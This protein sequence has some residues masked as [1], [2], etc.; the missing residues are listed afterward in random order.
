MFHIFLLANKVVLIK[1]TAL[2]YY[3]RDNSLM[4]CFSKNNINELFHH[5]SKLKNDLTE[6]EL[7]LGNEVYF[8]SLFEKCLKN[9]FIL[10]KN[11]K[12][13]NSEER[14]YLYEI[15]Q[16]IYNNIPIN[17]YVKYCDLSLFML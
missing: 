14:M 8:Y 5:F 13:S 4:H 7:W 11:S 9:L 16:G 2:Y 10:I 15:L 17:E 6:K 12:C 3:Q 1:G